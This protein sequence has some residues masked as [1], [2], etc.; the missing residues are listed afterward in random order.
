MTFKELTKANPT[1]E[2]LLDNA[3]IIIQ[4]I[5]RTTKNNVAL[6]LNINPTV[7]STVYK[8]LLAETNRQGR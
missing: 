4:E 1:Y 2:T 5:G 6:E 8:M 7:F 3:T